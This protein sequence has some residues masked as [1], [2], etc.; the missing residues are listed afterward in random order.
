MQKEMAIHSTLAWEIPWVEKPGGPV[1]GVAKES[2]TAKAT[3][4][5][6]LDDNITFLLVSELQKERVF[7][8]KERER[9]QI[10]LFPLVSRSEYFLRN[11][12]WVFEEHLAHPSSHANMCQHTNPLTMPHQR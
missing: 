4:Q 6:I 5:Q 9:K 10:A 2:N 7:K 1:C 8:K 3:K 11:L 12:L